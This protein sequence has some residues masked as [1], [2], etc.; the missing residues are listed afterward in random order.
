MPLWTLRSIYLFKLVFSYSLD[1]YPVGITGSPGSSAFNWG[2]G[3]LY[4]V[5]NKL[6]SNQ[7][8]A[9]ACFLHIANNICYWWYFWWQTFWQG[10]GDIALWVCC[11]FPWYWVILGTFSCACW[12]SVYLFW[13]NVYSSLLPIFNSVVFSHWVVWVVYIF[14]IL[15][16]NQ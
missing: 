14:W 5:C 16:Q 6:H 4:S 12:P 11:E 15:T 1:I 2:E 10:W 3:A 7:N 13:K 9:R 8:Y